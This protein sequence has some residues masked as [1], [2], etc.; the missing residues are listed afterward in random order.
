ML[1]SAELAQAR[2]DVA[3]MLPGTGYILSATEASDGQ[4]GFTATWGTVSA[5]SYRL[6]PLSG[7]R[8]LAGGAIQPFHAYQLTLPYNATITTAN[9]FKDGSGQVYAVR[10]VDAGKSWAVSLRAVLERI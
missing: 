2:A 8:L 3:N 4:G 6:D 5:V 1:T 10:S 9:R 7:N